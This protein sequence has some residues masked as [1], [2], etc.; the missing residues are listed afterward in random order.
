MRWLGKKISNPILI[1][2]VHLPALPGY[3]GSPG[4]DGVLASAL[5]DTATLQEA[6]FDGV[7]LENENDRP[8][9]LTTGEE[10]RKEF[11][12]LTLAVR[13]ETHL[14]V[15]LEILYDM[16]GSVDV[17][18]RSGA[19][20]VRLDV[21]ADEIETKWGRV[22]SPL[23]AIDELRKGSSA[24]PV[25]AVD[26]HVKHGT[27]IGSR[28]IEDST[29]VSLQNGA[30]AIIVTGTWTG[31]P[32]TEADC[33]ALRNV[34]GE[35]PLFT[36]SGLSSSNAAEIFKYCDGGIVATSIKEAGRI[37]LEKARELRRI[38]DGVMK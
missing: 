6:G 38:A 33:S 14:P 7:L 20:F 25:L 36:G 18:I 5:R 10:Y 12:R 19:P 32:P 27:V 24:M 3:P 16:P 4:F 34:C 26:V 21:F 9:E 23:S 29:R 11:A 37:D 30:G 1:G 35:T 2:V 22:P 31:I 28:S 8:H 15:G 17:A 13:A